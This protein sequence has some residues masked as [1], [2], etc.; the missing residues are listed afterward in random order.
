VIATYQAPE[1]EQSQAP[2]ERSR[3]TPVNVG[4]AERWLSLLGGGALA[5]FGLTRGSLGGLALAALGG[6]AAY[7]G[8]TG[9]CHAYGALGINTAGPRPA[10]TAIPA[11]TGIRVERA[12]TID[13]PAGE[14]YQFWRDLTN[15][16]EIMSHL[17]EVRVLEGNR[18]HWVAQAAGRRFEWDAEI[19]NEERDRLIA[20]RSLPGSEVDT[21]GS[22]H[23]ERAAG[24][25]GTVVRV[26]LKYNPPAG[27]LGAA[28]AWTFGDSA[29]Q[30]V[31]EDL[32]RFKQIM[33]AG[34][35]PTTR[36]QSSC[37]RDPDGRA[38]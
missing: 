22:V 27:K 15:L 14:L 34:E 25:R 20:W 24:G 37:R 38:G 11:G 9:H 29:D 12:V 33:E 16:P 28:L 3:P 10:A 30:Q 18:S 8:L 21:A 31:R 36:G 32:R 7:R 2:A 13:R 4:D 5:V 1:R 35:A 19:H 6:A 23:F 26:N 17:E